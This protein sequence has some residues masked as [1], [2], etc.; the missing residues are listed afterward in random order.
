VVVL[1]DI[2]QAIRSASESP[3]AKWVAPASFERETTKYW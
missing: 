2:Y 3:N 1:S